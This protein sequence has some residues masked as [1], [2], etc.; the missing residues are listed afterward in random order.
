M[1]KK[2]IEKTERL[3]AERLD[4]VQPLHQLLILNKKLIKR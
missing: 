2:K 1:I 4:S 3:A